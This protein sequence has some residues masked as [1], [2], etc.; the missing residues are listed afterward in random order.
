MKKVQDGLLGISDREKLNYS[1][2]KLLS[3]AEFS[4][5]KCRQSFENVLRLKIKAHEDSEP[6]V[7]LNLTAIEGAEEA[8]QKRIAIIEENDRCRSRLLNAL[9]AL[10]NR[11]ENAADGEIVVRINSHIQQKKDEK[12]VAAAAKRATSAAAKKALQNSQNSI[13]V[14]SVSSNV[15]VS[16]PKSAVNETLDDII[17]E[18]MSVNQEVDVCLDAAAQPKSVETYGS[19][20]CVVECEYVAEI[21]EVCYEYVPKDER[22]CCFSVCKFHRNHEFH[23]AQFIT[24]EGDAEA[25]R[26]RS[27][28]SVS[29]ENNSP[30]ANL[31][32]ASSCI[33]LTQDTPGPDGN[34]KPSTKKKRKL[35]H[36]DNVYSE[37]EVEFSRMQSNNRSRRGHTTKICVCSVC[38]AN[39]NLTEYE[40][41]QMKCCRVLNYKHRSTTCWGL[42]RGCTLCDGDDAVVDDPSTTST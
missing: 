20:C 37:I 16:E 25:N 23:Y 27:N 39:E 36:Y 21:A 42:S 28:S 14:S 34:L 26:R 22:Q 1:S 17:S 3:P 4:F 6:Y 11:H 29:L 13:S 8:C 33:S 40:E 2:S 10:R 35:S 38:V 19:V 9:Q 41:F 18:Q 5:Y 15:T 7:L 12:K 24:K 32:I 31:S 30:R